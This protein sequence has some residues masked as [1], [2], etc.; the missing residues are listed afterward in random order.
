MLASTGRF[1]AA[2]LAY[3]ISMCVVLALLI[4][5]FGAWKLEQFAIGFV[6]S[7]VFALM[8][9]PLRVAIPF[10]LMWI[11]IRAFGRHERWP[12]LVLGGLCGLF[13]FMAL[14][15]AEDGIWSFRWRDSAPMRPGDWQAVAGLVVSG[16]LGG[17]AA[18]AVG[19]RRRASGTGWRLSQS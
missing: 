1:L 12:F 2:Y 13:V 4:T 7:F 18:R 8:V 17:W 19:K 6:I 5:T 3:V 10:L 9:V 16:C 11:L 15:N 14:P